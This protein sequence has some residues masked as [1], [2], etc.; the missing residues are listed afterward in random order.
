MA[1]VGEGKKRRHER[2]VLSRAIKYVSAPEG[3]NQVLQGYVVNISEAG[4]CFVSNGAVSEGQEI[5]IRTEL[6]FFHQKGVVVWS[7]KID[8]TLF[9]AGLQCK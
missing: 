9:K 4:L 1:T 2:F 3:G 7:S 6:P 5:R 8:D